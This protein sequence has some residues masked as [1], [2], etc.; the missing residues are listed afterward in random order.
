VKEKFV[1]PEGIENAGRTFAEGLCGRALRNWRSTLNT[2]FVQKGKYARDVYGN[3]PLAVWEEFVDQKKTAE[4]V[5]LSVQQKEK[6][7]KAAENPHRLG[8]GGYAAK[9]ATWRKEEEERRVAGLPTIF[10]GMDERSRNWILARVLAIPP[11]D[12]VSFQKPLIEQIYQKLEGLAEMQKKGLFVPDKEKDMLTAVIETPEHPGRVRGISST[13]PWGKAFREHR[14]SYK[15]RDHYKKKLEDKMREIAKQ[16][17][18]GFFIQQQQQQASVRP[19]AENLI[20]GGFGQVPPN[21]MLAQIGAIPTPSRVGSIANAKHHVD[22]IVEDT[23]CKLVIPYGRKLDK[24]REVGT[25]M[26]LTGRVFPNPPPP[27][28]AWVQV[29]SI[30]D[31][32]CEIDIPTEDGIELLSVARNQYIL[33]HRRDIILN[34]SLSTLQPSQERVSPGSRCC[35]GRVHDGWGTWRR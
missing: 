11:D 22:E 35:N 17:L 20:S 33:W 16:E 19:S 4:A 34:A 31:E 7:M 27:E 32:S 1:Y 14:S 10:E 28:Y 26:T 5:A 3:I 24:F 30:S 12:N 2:E 15:K 13:L 8:L 25:T 29:V 18:I 6:A 23:P 21:M 9:M